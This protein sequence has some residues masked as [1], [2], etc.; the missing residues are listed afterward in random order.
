MKSPFVAVFR[1]DD[2]LEEGFQTI[3]SIGVPSARMSAPHAG[4]PARIPNI[5]EP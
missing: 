1:A 2:A 4:I 3:D 5:A